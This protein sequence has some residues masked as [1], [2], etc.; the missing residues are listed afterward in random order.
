MH[1]AFASDVQQLFEEVPEKR[2]IAD[3]ALRNQHS[4]VVSG[5]DVDTTKDEQLIATLIDL[6]I[7]ADA[8]SR[9]DSNDSRVVVVVLQVSDKSQA[10]LHSRL[11]V[12]LLARKNEQLT[13]CLQEVNATRR[14]DAGTS[15]GRRKSNSDEDEP[16][17]T[18]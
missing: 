1:A 15:G 2:S 12:R 10:L 13:A 6:V 18:A 16:F 9:L 4:I 5:V 8:T 14:R 3:D 7:V 17:H 11:T